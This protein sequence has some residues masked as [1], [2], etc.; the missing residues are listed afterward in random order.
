MAGTPTTVTV[1]FTDLVGSTELFSSLAPDRAEA[2]RDQF[3]SLL[4]GAVSTSGG[5]EVK[6]LGDGLMVAFSSQSRALAGAVGMQQAI[7]RHNRRAEARLAIRVG[8]ST[9][10]ATREDGDYFGEPVTE[11]A[12]LCAHAEGGQILTTA[13]TRVMAGRHATQ[14]FVDLG[15]T[16]FD[17]LPDPVGVTEVRWAPDAEA[18]ERGERLP[19]PPRLV[20]TSAESVF[21]FCGRAEELE[22]LNELHKRGAEG[23]L[24]IALV[25]GE[26]GVGKTALIAQAA[27]SAHRSGSDVVYGTCEEGL[28]VPYKPWVEALN[29]LVKGLADEILHRFAEDNDLGVARLLPSLARRIGREP[30]PPG[31]DSDAERFL[32]MEGVVRLLEV[33]SEA[34]PLF[35]VLDDLHWA[36]AASLQLLAHLARSSLPMRVM[37]AGTFRDSDLSRGHPLTS[38]LA[39]LRRQPSARRLGLVGLEEVEVIGLMEVAAGHNLPE[40]GVALAHAIRRE[41]GGNPFFVIELLRHLAQEGTFAQGDDDRWHLTVDF[42]EVGLPTSVREVV[43]QRI[44][45]LGEESHRTLAM[46]AVIGRDFDLA[47]L[48]SVLQTDE[49]DLADLLEAATVAGVVSEVPGQ[50]ERYRFVH[51]LIQH[52]LYQDLSAARRRRAH[53]T[54]ALVLEETPTED[55]E[56]LAALARHWLAATRPVDT[57]KAVHYARRAGQAALDTYAPL[58]AVRWFTDALEALERHSVE[59]EQTRCELLVDLG[60]AQNRAGIPEH[61]AT[62]LQ[63]AEIARRM[64]HRDLLVAAALGGRRGDSRFTEADPERVEV[65]REALEVLDD[66]AAMRRALLLTSLAEV[67]D[68]RDWRRRRELAD[69]AVTITEPLE[70]G[71]RAEVLVAC[72]QYRCQPEL[73]GVRLAETLS[74]C[75][76]A[77]ERGDPVMRVQACYNRVHAAMEVGDIE[78]VDRRIAEMATLVKRSGLPYSTW[79]LLITKGWRS[80]LAGDLATAE[81]LNDELLA[82]GSA[83]GIAEVLGVYGA[84]LFQLRD[85]QGRVEEMIE[86]FAEVAAANP[87]LAVLRVALA[88]AY[89]RVGRLDDG[90]RQFEHDAATAF[91]EIP[92]DVTWTTA[93]ALAL[94]AAAALRHGDAATTLYDLLAPSARLVLFN[95]GTCGGPMARPL[96]RAAHLLGRLEEAH[97]HFKAAL[98]L[99]VRIAAPYWEAC[100]QLDYADVLKDLGGHDE[101]H[102]L[103]A[104]AVATANHFG[105]VGLARRA[106]A[107]TA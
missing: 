51:A 77:E 87:A 46:A 84:L 38:L 5:T 43:A 10:E 74:V 64:G 92:R 27:R 56:R 78:E 20:A 32:I 45:S 4:R 36:D 75:R 23:E 2:L 40:E 99:S 55:P 73:S 85:L 104:K 57:T 8:L 66:G 102:Q 101:A 24:G 106:E 9:G 12:R 16:T 76:T 80:A 62:L 60:T 81:G 95:Q 13:I 71:A 59:D 96:G 6:N 72:Y 107:F 100:T 54:V 30:G 67:T 3:F 33:A 94:D 63:A 14:E 7:E 103:V 105:F 28:G 18:P 35:V 53:E 79:L 37:V 11:A 52:T 49:M 68:A 89:C 48:A 82:I 22:F 17:G 50:V 15:E 61:R 70:A 98:D 39:D 83:M 86:P 25:S 41:S 69:E 19:L 29:P 97:A 21:A 88:E 90:A 93:M 31:A 91:D 58:D 42:E 44:A 47:V 1:L 26:P 65:L 34:T